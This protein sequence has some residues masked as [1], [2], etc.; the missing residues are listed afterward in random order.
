MK[1][2]FVFLLIVVL[3]PFSS[4]TAQERPNPEESNLLARW[5]ALGKELKQLKSKLGEFQIRFNGTEDKA[6]RDTIE[7]NYNAMCAKYIDDVKAHLANVD[8][9]ITKNPK[10]LALRKRRAEDGVFAWMDSAMRAEDC[11]V[12][13]EQTKNKKYLELAAKFHE[14]GYRYG[15]CAEVWGRLV[16]MAPSVDRAYSYGTALMNNLEFIAAKNAFKNGL[17]LAKDDK[18]RNKLN[19]AI[20]FADKY[21][22]DWPREQKLREEARI[23]NNLP[24]VE[25]DTDRGTM[26]LELFEDQAPNTV[27][28][29]ISLAEKGFYD[30][31][32]FHRCIANFMIQGGDPMGTGVGGPGYRIKDECGEGFDIRFHYPGSLSMAKSAGQANSGGSQFFVTS[33]V[34]GPLNGRHTVFGRVLKGIE[35]THIKALDVSKTGNPFKIKSIRVLKKRDHPYKVE[36]FEG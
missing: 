11:E 22:K 19:T 3:L 6:K 36:K 31:G 4:A 2:H 12:L 17:P 25:I 27:A 5:D 14:E 15:A 8:D 18:E 9:Y 32:K 13:F 28:N 30:D 1:S 34:T 24:I 7:V 26:T 35:L 16:K 29:F 10:S 23:K 20:D 21:V 33:G